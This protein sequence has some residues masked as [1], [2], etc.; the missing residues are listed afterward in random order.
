MLFLSIFLYNKNS[1]KTRKKGLRCMKVRSLLFSF[2]LVF[3]GVF[4][5][6]SLSLSSFDSAIA[7]EEVVLD[8]VSIWDGEDVDESEI[9]KQDFELVTDSENKESYYIYTAKGF[10]YFANLANSKSFADASVYLC[11]NIDLNYNE[12]NPI[13]AS[14][15]LGGVDFSGTFDGQGYA[16]Y[17]LKISGYSG[18]FAGLFAYLNTGTI[19]NLNLINVDIEASSMNIGGLVGRVYGL[20]AIVNCQVSG[21]ITSSNSSLNTAVGGLVGDFIGLNNAGQQIYDES[22]DYSLKPRIKHSK[23]AIN[24]VGGYSTGGLVGNVSGGVAIIESSNEGSILGSYTYAGGLVGRSTPTDSSLALLVTNSYNAGELE[25]SNSSNQ[26]VGGLL[27]YSSY[28]GS[29]NYTSFLIENSFN[30]GNFTSISNS[31]AKIGGLVGSA[32]SPIGLFPGQNTSVSGDENYKGKSVSFYNVFNLGE[33]F[34]DENREIPLNATFSEIINCS[35]AFSPLAPNFQKIYY[36]NDSIYKYSTVN[37]DFYN[38]VSQL[39]DSALVSFVSRLDDLSRSFEFD[40]FDTENVDKSE[41]WGISSGINDGYPYLKGCVQV[42]S[43]KSGLTT[44]ESL[45]E[46]EGTKDKPYLIYTA[47]DLARVSTIYNNGFLDI[48]GKFKLDSSEVLGGD[49]VGDSTITYFSLQ[50]D[51][52]LSL[53]AWNPIGNGE[54][55]EN[56]YQREFINAVFDGNNFT[57]SGVNVSMHANYNYLGLFGYVENSIL[58]NI[59]IDDYRFIGTENTETENAEKIYKATLAGLVTNSYIINC[60]DGN[61]IEESNTRIKTANAGANAYVVFGKNNLDMF[62]ENGQSLNLDDNFKELYLSYVNTNDGTVYDEFTRDTIENGYNSGKGYMVHI[63]RPEFIFDSNGKIYGAINDAFGDLYLSYLPKT[64]TKE[65]TKFVIVKEGYEISSYSFLSQTANAGEEDLTE[66]SFSDGNIDSLISSGV[67]ATW[68][69]KEQVSAQIV[70]NAYENSYESYDIT[71]NF[72]EE[73]INFNKYYKNKRF[74]VEVLKYLEEN[75]IYREGYEVVGIYTDFDKERHTFLGANYMEDG[76]GLFIYYG[77]RI[78]I[79]WQGCQEYNISIKLQDV[80]DSYKQNNGI[81]TSEVKTQETPT[82]YSWQDAVEKVEIVGSSLVENNNLLE[83]LLDGSLSFSYSTKDVDKAYDVEKIEVILTLKEGFVFDNATSSGSLEE[84]IDDSKF[85]N[86]KTNSSRDENYVEKYGYSSLNIVNS[87]DEKGEYVEKNKLTISLAQIVGNGELNIGIAREN[88]VYDV[89]VDEDVKF[90]LTLPQIATNL[91]SISI[92][93]EDGFVPLRDVSQNVNSVLSTKNNFYFGLNLMDGYFIFS[94]DS[95]DVNTIPTGYIHNYEVSEDKIV[96][97]EIIINIV[98]SYGISNYYLVKLSTNDNVRTETIYSISR[99]NLSYDSYEIT[100]RIAVLVEGYSGDRDGIVG[101]NP[102]HIEYYTNASFGLVFSTENEITEIVNYTS[103]P[104]YLIYDDKNENGSFDEGNEELRKLF[105]NI[106][107]PNGK[108]GTIL[109]S[110][111]GDKDSNI[112]EIIISQVETTVS[113]NFK[114]A[115]LDSASQTIEILEEENL[116]SVDILLYNRLD[117]LVGEYTNVNSLNLNTNDYQYMTINVENS[118]HYRWIYTTNNFLIG[119]VKAEDQSGAQQVVGSNSLYFDSNYADSSIFVSPTSEGMYTDNIIDPDPQEGEQGFYQYNPREDISSY[120]QYSTLNYDATYHYYHTFRMTFPTANF[121]PVQFDVVFIVE[122]IEYEISVS[123]QYLADSTTFEDTVNETS[124]TLNE[125]ET[126]RNVVNLKAKDSFLV[127][128]DSDATIGYNFVG[129]RVIGKDSYT[130]IPPNSNVLQ[131]NFEMSMSEFLDNYKNGYTLTPQVFDGSYLYEIVAVYESEYVDYRATFNK[132]LI[133][134]YNGTEE[135]YLSSS[136][137]IGQVTSDVLNGKFYYN[138]SSSNLNMGLTEIDFDFKLASNNYYEIKGYAVLTSADYNK[139]NGSFES[140]TSGIF[141]SS[142][143]IVS[144]SDVANYLRE[145]VFDLGRED[146]LE[147][148]FYIVPILRQKTLQ[149][150]ITS[151]T[152]E[153]VY[154]SEKMYDTTESAIT[155]K[156]YYASG[157]TLSFQTGLIKNETGSADRNY[158]LS[159]SGSIAGLNT[160]VL[161]NIFNLRVGYNTQSGWIITY[162][163]GERRTTSPISLQT[164]YSQENVNINGDS[165]YIIQIKRNWTANNFNIN[166]YSGDSRYNSTLGF[167]SDTAIFGTATGNMSVQNGKYDQ[168]QNLYANGFSLTG[169]EFSKWRVYKTYVKDGATTTEF[170]GDYEEGASVKNIITG[171]NQILNEQNYGTLLQVY[172]LWTPKT[173]TVKLNTNGGKFSFSENNE[174]TLQLVY[175]KPFSEAEIEGVTMEELFAENNDKLLR[176]HFIFDGFYVSD[177]EE[178]EKE[179]QN[180]IRLNTYFRSDILSFVDSTESALT[181]Y[182][183]W[184]YNTLYRPSLNFF[185]ILQSSYSG[186]EVEVFS[187]DFQ[188]VQSNSL[189]IENTEGTFDITYGTN[190]EDYGVDI[191]YSFASLDGKGRVIAPLEEKGAWSF[192]VEKNVGDY[193]FVMTLTLVDSGSIYYSQGS[194]DTFSTNLNIRINMADVSF[195]MSEDKEIWLENLRYMV[196]LVGFNEEISKF[197]SYLSFA[198]FVEDLNKTEVYE[199]FTFT[200]EIAY[201]YVFMKY[202]NMINAKDS[203]FHIYKNWKYKDNDGDNT[204]DYYSYYSGINYFGQDENNEN[205]ENTTESRQE[206]KD[207]LDNSLFVYS[208]E[209]GNDYDN[210]NYIF[211]ENVTSRYSLNSILLTSLTAQNIISS[212]ISISRIALDN[213]S[214]I[215]NNSYEV[216]AY[217]KEISPNTLL[218]YNLNQDDEGRFYLSLGKAFMFVQVLKVQNNALSRSKYY[219]GEVADV[220]WAKVDQ[221]Y[222]PFYD[223]TILYQYDTQSETPLPLDDVYLNFDITTANAGKKDENIEFSYYDEEN[224]LNIS[225]LR[226]YTFFGDSMFDYTNYY[227]YFN[228]LLDESFV[229][230]IFNVEDTAKIDLSSTY[231]TLDGIRFTNQSLSEDIVGNLEN[232]LFSIMS[233]TYSLDSALTQTVSNIDE[234]GSA[235]PLE[236]GQFYTSDGKILLFTLENNNSI[237]PIFYTSASI[238]S[239]EIKIN[240]TKFL[241]YIKFYGIQNELP[242]DINTY[243]SQTSYT[244]YLKTKNEDGIFQNNLTYVD[245]S[246]TELSYYGVYSD[247]VRLNYDIN[248]PIESGDTSTL[249]KLGESTVQDVFVPTYSNLIMSDL[250]YNKNGTEISYTNLFENDLF[251]GADKTNPHTPIQLKTYWKMNDITLTQNEFQFN[252]AVGSVQNFYV[253]TVGEMS[254]EESSFFDYTYEIYKVEDEEE[255]LL[256]S[257]SKLSSLNVSFENGGSVSDNG[258]YL[259]KVSVTIKDNYKYILDTTSEMSKE[260]SLGFSITFWK[261]QVT[262]LEYMT[263]SSDIEYDGFDH[264]NSFTIALS[265]QVFDPSTLDY[266]KVETTNYQYNSSN[267]VTIKVKFGE[268]EVSSIK[269]VGEYGIS[270]TLDEIFFDFDPT[271]LMNFTYTIRRL[272]IN[273]ANETISLSKNFNA[274]NLPITYTTAIAN[275]RIT[276]TFDREN[277]N[278]VYSEDIGNYDLYLTSFSSLQNSNFTISYNSVVLFD[279]ENYTSDIETTRVGSFQIV[280]SGDL[281][282]GWE[283]TDMVGTTITVPFSEK[284]YSVSIQD[285]KIH[286]ISD[287]ETVTSVNVVLYDIVQRKNVTNEAVLNIIRPFLNNVLIKLTN[288]NNTFDKAINSAV[289]YLNL[290]MINQGIYSYYNNVTFS[291]DNAVQILPQELNLE[292]YVF[293]KEFDGNNKIYIDVESKTKIDEIELFDGIY[294]EGTFS[295]I[296]ANENIM[297]QV[298]LLTTDQTLYPLTNFEL[299]ESST[300]GAIKKRMANINFTFAMFEDKENFNYGDLTQENFEN[301]ISYT[302]SDGEEDLTALFETSVYSMAFYLIGEN[303][304]EAEINSLGYIYAGKYNLEMQGFFQDFDLTAN[305]VEI[306]ILPFEYQF[307]IEKNYIS[308]SVL[309]PISSFYQQTLYIEETGDTFLVNFYV[310]KEIVGQT[311]MAGD[312]NLTLDTNNTLY[313]QTYSNGNI[314]LSINENNEGFNVATFEGTLFLQIENEEILKRP[315]NALNYTILADETAFIITVENE[316]ETYT[317][318]SPFKFLTY[319]GEDFEEVEN[320][321]FESISIT[322]QGT[323]I[324]KSAGSYKLTL[325]ANATGY[326]N[327]TFMKSYTF[328]IEK[329]QIE[330]Q[331]GM[332]DKTYDGTI[333]TEVMVEDGVF[334]GDSLSIRAIYSDA[335]VGSNKNVRLVLAGSSANNYVLNKTQSTGTIFARGAQVRLTKDDFVY[336]DVYKDFS[337]SYEIFYML[338]DEEIIVPNGLYSLKS[339]VID[340]D[341]SGYLPKGEYEVTVEIE[342]Q[343]FNI[344]NNTLSFTVSARTLDFNFISSGEYMAPYGTEETLSS[345]F[346]RNYTTVYGD[347]L[348]IEFERESGAE[349]GYYKILGA[350]IKDNENYVIGSVVDEVNAYRIVSSGSLVYL[351]ASDKEVV[352]EADD[353]VILSFVYDGITYDTVSLRVDTENSKYVLRISTSLGAIYHDFELNLYSYSEETKSYTRLSSVFDNSIVATN[354]TINEDIKNVGT[355][356]IYNSDVISD[357]FVVQLGKNNRTSAFEVKVEK[358][359]VYFKNTPI[360]KEFDNQDAVLLYEDASVVLEN[361]VAG[362]VISLKLT[363]VDD[364]NLTAKYV[365]TYNLVGEIGGSENYNLVTTLQDKVTSVVG[366]ITK[367]PIKIVINNQTTVYGNEHTHRDNFVI[368]YDF[369]SDTIDLSKYEKFDEMSATFTLI[370]KDANIYSSSG[371]LKAQEYSIEL[372][373]L[374]SDDFYVVGYISN[375]SDSKN[376]T[377]KYTILPLTLQIAQ[378]EES[379]DTIFAKFFDNSTLLNIFDSE[380]NLKFNL[381]G[382]IEGDIVSISEANFVDVSV[383]ENLEVKFT[384]FGD[385]SENYSLSSY[386]QGR[387]K[388]ITI[389]LT[390]DKG[391]E[392]D[393]ENENIV[394]NVPNGTETLRYMNFPFAYNDSLTSN[395]QNENTMSISS[396]PSSLSGKIGHRFSHWAMKFE[397]AVDSVE[398]IFLKN[399][400]SQY[401]LTENHDGTVSSISVSNSRNT[402]GFLN[403]LLNDENDYFGLYY[404][405]KEKIGIEFVAVWEVESYLFSVTTIKDGGYVSNLADTLITLKY[406][407][408]ETEVKMSSAIYQNENVFYGTSIEIMI[409][410]VE[411]MKV[412]RF[413]DRTTNEALDENENIK[414]TSVYSRDTNR[415]TTTF[416]ITSLQSDMNIGVEIDDKEVFV[417][418]DLTNCLTASIDDERFYEYTLGKYLWKASIEELD[419]LTLEDLPSITNVGSVILGYRFETPTGFSDI[420]VDSFKNTLLEN[421]KYSTADGNDYEILYSPYD[422]AH[423]VTIVLNYNYD[424]NYENDQDD[425]K[426]E[427]F[428]IPYLEKFSYSEKWIETPERYGYD[429]LGWFESADG[430]KITG[431]SKVNKTGSIVLYAKWQIQINTVYLTFD[432]MDLTSS[433]IDGQEVEYSTS[434]TN[435]IF[436]NLTFGKTLTLEFKLDLGYSIGSVNYHYFDSDKIEV[437]TFETKDGVGIVTFTIPAKPEVY[438]EVRS[439]KN[440]NTI[441][442]S[443][444]H[445]LLK[446][447]KDTA[448]NKIETSS[449]TFMVESFVDVVI[450]IEI[451]EGYIYTKNSL[452]SNF[453]ESYDRENNIL[454]INLNNI[455]SHMTIAIETRERQNFITIEFQNDDLIEDFVVNNSPTSS[456]EFEVKTGDSFVFYVDLTHG[457][458]IG[459]LDSTRDDTQFDVEV[460]DDIT[461]RYNGYQIVTISVIHSDLK[462]TINTTKALFNVTV[463]VVNFDENGEEV[464]TNNKA[465][466]LSGGK[467]LNEI[468][469]YYQDSIS[470]IAEALDLSYRFA[471]FADYFDGNN[472]NIIPSESEMTYVVE[473]NVTIYAVFSALQYNLTLS[474]YRYY[475]LDALSGSN[476]EIFEILYQQNFYEDENRQKIINNVTLYYGSSQSVYYLVPTGY[477]YYGYGYFAMNDSKKIFLRQDEMAN[478]GE[479]IEINLSYIDYVNSEENNFVLFVALKPIE[480]TINVSSYLDFD[481]I[482]EKDKL[483]GNISLVDE[484]GNPVNS[485]GYISGTNNHYASTSFDGQLVDKRDFDIISYTASTLYLKVFAERNN[486]YFKDIL[487]EGGLNINSLGEFVE[488]GRIYYIYEISNIVGGRNANIKVLF[489]GEKKTVDFKFINRNNITVNGGSFNYE[490]TDEN[491][492]KVWS[493]GTNNDN[494][495]VTAFVDTSYKVI[496]YVRLGFVID[497]NLT[498]VTYNSRLV[499]VSNITFEKVLSTATNY[500]YIIRFDVSGFVDNS[501]INICLVPQTYTVLLRDTTISDLES[502]VLVEINNVEFHKLLDLSEENI[503]NLVF[504]EEIFHFTD[505]ILNVVQKKENFDFGGYFSLENGQGIQYINGVGVA[506]NFFME[507]GYVLD[508]KTNMYVFSENAQIIDGEI[509]IS[510]YLNWIYLKT[511]ITFELIPDVIENIDATSIVKGANE[512][513]SWFGESYPLYMEVAFDSNLT[514]TAPQISGYKFYRFVIKQRNSNGEWLNDVISFQDSVPWSTNEFDRI[515]EVHVQIQYFA[516]IDV[517]LYGGDMEYEIRQEQEDSA[518]RLL[519]NEGYVNTTKE[520][521][522]VALDSDGYN[523]EYWL[524]LNT[525]MQYSSQEVSLSVN[526]RT[527]FFLACEGRKVNLLFDEYNAENGQIVILQINSK[528]GGLS[529]RVLGSYNQNGDFVKS[530]LEYSVKVGDT[531]TFLTKIDFGYGAEWNLNEI[532]LQRFDSTYYYFSMVID[533]D[534]ADQ[535]LQIIPT[536]SGESVALYIE[537]AFKNVLEG[538]VDANNAEVAGSLSYNENSKVVIDSIFKDIKIETVVNL[539]YSI[540]NITI[541][542]PTGKSFDV[543]EFYDASMNLITLSSTYLIENNIAGTLSMEVVFDRLYYKSP[544]EFT[545]RGDGTEENPYEIANADDL[546]YYMEKINSG[547]IDENQLAYKDASYILLEDIDLVEKFWTPIGTEENAFNG[548]FNFNGHKVTSINLAKLYSITSYSGLFGVLGGDAK[549]IME[550]TNYWYIYVI[551]G[552]V[553]L[554]GTLLVILLVWNKRKKKKREELEVR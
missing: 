406:G 311:N 65:V 81:I 517:V 480:T 343:N 86:N 428:T 230:T 401:N 255:I 143:N 533:E 383:G 528:S 278:G 46:G 537:K 54:K 491:S 252:Y 514:F 242:Q 78:Y 43:N 459:E 455:S 475:K 314:T 29:A 256:S 420:G 333:T 363:F 330:V 69:E 131:D 222:R 89:S 504:D 77:E 349:V 11:S 40:F 232:G 415:T 34:V 309:D 106:A 542:S 320:L 215:P 287:G 68:E 511:Q 213:Q 395:S 257:N 371:Y 479:L 180:H 240:E 206:R 317:E 499:N 328:E 148:T 523:F 102:Y 231:Y 250:K 431:E 281:R 61:S 450:T 248:L 444:E 128:T 42:L 398:H 473:D 522:L 380:N 408:E 145:T 290:E 429:F 264:I 545:E 374:V 197:Q 438:L 176:P 411:D 120:F 136:Y 144:G 280:K 20:S 486:Y 387:I 326:Q 414:I 75:N 67:T 190:D 64:P 172:A 400:A 469:V 156:Y 125:E 219:D 191:I 392:S 167:D 83:D 151:G 485:N 243:T 146:L 32:T 510:L 353:G 501:E 217:I 324:F 445:A 505:G 45:W 153:V 195:K 94:S 150:E 268:E 432:N 503:E 269:N 30:R 526:E 350:S 147:T 33:I 286:I 394:S 235:I 116:P 509:V 391:G 260:A 174:I 133:D 135:T 546:S 549:I 254:E 95:F 413:F 361:I 464:V 27:G 50:N 315:Y 508:E 304:Q 127:R 422:E 484:N 367:A 331:D 502:D 442:I 15:S 85:S 506:N 60:F 366:E 334:E 35:N 273:L 341:G 274:D 447:V 292:E 373:E 466:I 245:G 55:F 418:L 24:I 149:I 519:I 227:L 293:E 28:I 53:K 321:Q 284:G 518:S 17:N 169:Y 201:E 262:K 539:R 487:V 139:S 424:D 436:E 352:T 472:Y 241:E 434:G 297:L 92:L 313:K 173:Y 6:Y 381:V 207:V 200:D 355:Y 140:S 397:V 441:T 175:N 492:F 357:N 73:S 496:V 525:N 356:F 249:L 463:K 271:L 91:S 130:E 323:N 342:C 435:L 409:E 1:K 137:G 449:N 277:E 13:G 393:E 16:I 181:V 52:N 404:L 187:Y 108:N 534:Y 97:G 543:T 74:E 59:K 536:F 384:L 185:D 308:V 359:D 44:I 452:T 179:K 119:K 134:N 461:S 152:S 104:N 244:I 182:A 138:S 171:A 122:E 332:F 310:P 437:E 301:Q 63:G 325:S 162:G 416:K 107:K 216:R 283:A 319:N 211:A 453:T 80:Y 495:K 527:T 369:D 540:V 8:D 446:E 170:L 493:N 289:Y 554:L 266:G 96:N 14:S 318:E 87:T 51:I 196:S 552:V 10:K 403:A 439:V 247:L 516:K 362:D 389:E 209:Y 291:Q 298:L 19:K 12:W 117:S 101:T 551:V 347:K 109:E 41:I 388:P 405:G 31:S 507:T 295:D 239:V 18:Q 205:I 375:D 553:A 238:V 296:H 365:G 154:D 7:S 402:I 430:E 530:M 221:N 214:A 177:S 498:F 275:E 161:N 524:N 425:L 547:A 370:G 285:G 467:E 49:V 483:A 443:G 377:A 448:G 451:E 202:Y 210:S 497:E 47:G 2:L 71:E 457:Y 372:E 541:K 462:I 482:E 300:F 39:N 305:N 344:T 513:N 303:D 346:T 267:I 476:E 98:N 299:K 208:Y 5:A 178:R 329:K 234:N 270:V 58:R 105:Y 36:D 494:M 302:V 399:L 379:F 307:D 115:T 236:N 340:F 21:E 327:V 38:K 338:G 76:N 142:T 129:F 544:N 433:Q 228:V 103:K 336:G 488:N 279:G 110:Y 426:E 335:N 100:D 276:F 348:E 186:E 192:I 159:L 288:L 312:Y 189:T 126:A 529:T 423:N 390:F 123:S 165:D 166:Y 515:V 458:A 212:E 237:N 25:I 412:A 3:V 477:T 168:E 160:I 4:G 465:Y 229:F 550:K 223:G 282:L 468:N 294:F 470:L 155:M 22:G 72:F 417:T 66:E 90:G 218:N 253:E 258:N 521:T 88:H 204:N 396:F 124:I 500:T 376:L 460:I 440:N 265:Y 410:L 99:N 490:T 9:S 378:K 56:D 385:D 157:T 62:K 199:D 354:F 454:T 164:Y 111:L 132:F 158:S 79:E 184:K 183:T 121:W 474:S 407:D 538:A 163:G 26:N 118:N 84:I 188:N 386:M 113:F 220:L 306:N 224:Y 520:F 456:R 226:I 421:F 225:N 251:V 481:G 112:T 478:S 427:N 360:T 345:K 259:F 337:F 531:V 272:N 198:E 382:T 368:I 233:F 193:V 322:S 535:S 93:G 548:M 316:N 358:R 339:A 246:V 471:G 70:Y 23:S 48:D 194:F 351:L 203:S 263:T 37:D 141:E 261:H 489:K 114:F 532:E 364:N 82:N 57:I 419:M 512:Y